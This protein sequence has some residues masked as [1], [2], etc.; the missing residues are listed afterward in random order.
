MVKH[1]TCKVEEVSSILTSDMGARILEHGYG[2]WFVV[3]CLMESFDIQVIQD[4]N[5]ICTRR[6]TNNG[7]QL[8]W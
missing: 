8:R 5:K 3:W 6:N 7:K 2:S 4:E 1:S